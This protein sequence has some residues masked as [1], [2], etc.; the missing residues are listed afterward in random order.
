MG[1]PNKIS[2]AGS[3]TLQSPEIGAVK[4]PRGAV[5]DIDSG[6]S[7]VATVQ[8]K[9][10]TNIEAL[11]AVAL[12]FYELEYEFR[13]TFMAPSSQPGSIEL[14]FLVYHGLLHPFQLDGTFAHKSAA[15]KSRDRDRD[16]VLNQRLMPMGAIPIVRIPGDKLQTV[17]DC[18]REIRIHVRV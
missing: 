17:E 13:K 12:D 1:R 5:F 6:E 16:A 14:D 7:L 2:I 15:Q 3:L 10:A 4:M 18:K 9:Q 11:F 8:G